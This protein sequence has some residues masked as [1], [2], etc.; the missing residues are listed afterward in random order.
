MKKVLII[1][2]YWPPLG[3]AG[4]QRV[5]KFAKYL[6]EF[7]WQP[8]VLTVENGDAPVIDKSLFTDIPKE[9]KIYKTKAFQPYNIY[10]KFTSKPA[11]EKI[12]S[13][14]LIKKNNSLKEKLSNWIRLNVFLPD[15]KVGWIPFAFKEGL[16]I[17]NKENI[18][19]IFSSSPPHTVQLI[20][21]KLAKK[22]GL[23]LIADLRDPWMELIHYQANKRAFFAKFIESKLER[24]ALDSAEEIIL[25]RASILQCAMLPSMSQA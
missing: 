1:T 4:V 24:G 18:A 25:Q 23:K 9:C 17:I 11:D 6:P 2:Y 16:K 12:P 3:G 7:G 19:L 15:A 13:D 8:I 14:V 21:K 22:T 10:K 20:A 5:L